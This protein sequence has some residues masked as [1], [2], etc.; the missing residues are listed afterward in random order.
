[1]AQTI[2]FYYLLIIFPSKIL[3]SENGAF[4]TFYS[5]Y[6]LVILN[7]EIATRCPVKKTSLNFWRIIWKI[8][9]LE[10]IFEQ[11]CKVNP[12]YLLND[13]YCYRGNFKHVTS[14]FLNICNY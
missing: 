7:P 4:I 12:L 6:Y 3:S 13:N 10:I 11:I 5:F 9:V 1:M 14:E 2:I 8:P